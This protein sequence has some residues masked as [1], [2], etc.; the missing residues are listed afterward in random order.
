MVG[1]DV[2]R[3]S[4]TGESVVGDADGRISVGSIEGKSVD[5]LVG[6]FVVGDTVV[7]SGLHTSQDTGQVSNTFLPLPSLRSF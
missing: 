3:R 1:F 2:G 6:D 4:L 5:I 7:G